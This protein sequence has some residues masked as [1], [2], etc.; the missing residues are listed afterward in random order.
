MELSREGDK[1]SPRGVAGFGP[2]LRDIFCRTARRQARCCYTANVE[3]SHFDHRLSVVAE[4]LQQMQTKLTAYTNGEMSPGVHHSTA[5]AEN[6]TYKLAFLF[7]DQGSQYAN[8]GREL[9]E[10]QSTFRTALDRCSEILGDYLDEPLLNIL[11]S[12]SNTR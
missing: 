1:K 5:R 3:R 10:T 7:T 9:Y 11:S 4:S 12:L 2:A 6:P 8:M